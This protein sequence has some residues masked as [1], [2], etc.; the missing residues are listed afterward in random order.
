MSTSHFADFLLEELWQAY[1]A[2]RLGKRHT[3]DE[4]RF[5]L[6]AMTNIINLRDSVL[7]RQYT[8]SRGVAFIVRDPVVREIVAAPFRDRIIHHFLYNLCANWWDRRFIPDSYSC[9]K[10]KGTLYGQKRLL[11]HIA[12]V[13]NHY[14]SSAFVIKLDIQGYFMSLKHQRLY[15]RVTWGLEQQFYHSKLSDLKN[16]IRC[17]S[18]DKNKLYNTARY[19]WHQIIFDRPMHNIAIRGQRSDWKVLPKSKSL[20]N[21]PAGQGIVIGNLTSQL[22]SNIY[23]DQLDRF[24]KFELNYAHYG[25]YVDDFFIVVPLTKREQLLR[26]I[27]VIRD[28]LKHQLEL[29]LHP[30]KCHAQ[31]AEKGVP[32]IG[33][34]I[35]PGF[36]IP[37]KRVRR[38]AYQAAYK[39]T[40]GNTENLEGFISRLGSNEHINHRRFFKQL[41]DT[42]GWEYNWLSDSEY[43]QLHPNNHNHRSSKPPSPFYSQT[44]LFDL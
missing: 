13:T 23:L 21:Q 42:F 29:T 44:S 28:F 32:F 10:N 17:Q 35:Y 2:A 43:Q 34:V 30:N 3:I 6:N 24:I 12:S 27:P 33:A 9:R 20:F 40:T 7:R 25:R 38:K 26:D 11:H 1:Q 31:V 8:P 19:L 4:H 16:D 22:L 5:E 36:I 15:Q 37:G 41:F 39:L 18:S 14:T